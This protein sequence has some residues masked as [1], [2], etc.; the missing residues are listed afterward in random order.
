MWLPY[1]IMVQF[2]NLEMRRQLESKCC[3]I[4][5]KGQRC[6]FLLGGT[7]RSCSKR[8]NLVN[9]STYWDVY[10]L[11]RRKGQIQLKEGVRQF[12][13]LLQCLS[14]EPPPAKSG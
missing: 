13:L 7:L 6:L 10:R 12:P 4:S 2:Y 5:E 8:G 9:K 14:I 11:E 3:F 1:V